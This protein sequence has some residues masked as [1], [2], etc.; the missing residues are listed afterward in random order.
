MAESR[1]PFASNSRL[2]A[3]IRSTARASRLLVLRMSTDD[4]FVST[5]GATMKERTAN[6]LEGGRPWGLV[7]P[8]SAMPL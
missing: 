6:G 4:A 8:H 1:S 3:R 7:Y 5:A 2:S